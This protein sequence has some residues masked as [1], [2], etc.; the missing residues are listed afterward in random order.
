MFALFILYRY[1]L[2]ALGSGTE[3]LKVMVDVFPGQSAPL[4]LRKRP[5]ERMIREL[6]CCCK[7]M[8]PH[9]QEVFVTF[10]IRDHFSFK[11]CIHFTGCL[12]F[13]FSPLN[14]IECKIPAQ[15][16]SENERSLC[17]GVHIPQCNIQLILEVDDHLAGIHLAP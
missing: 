11:L 4:L 15:C 16:C 6:F 7:F 5:E 3:L 10:K 8:Q 17:R 12:F 1:R 14:N 9:Q 2:N 13:A